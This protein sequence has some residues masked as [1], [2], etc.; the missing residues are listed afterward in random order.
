MVGKDHVGIGSNFDGCPTCA[1]DAR[2]GRPADDHRRYGARSV[3]AG[4]PEAGLKRLFAQ[5]FMTVVR[6]HLIGF[7]LRFGGSGSILRSVRKVKLRCLMPLN[8][9]RLTRN[10]RPAELARCS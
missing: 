10:T 3:P 8:A 4:H 1:W 7:S 9:V 5:M 2:Y 6:D